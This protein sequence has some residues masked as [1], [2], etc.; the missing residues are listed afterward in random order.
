M[1]VL[2]ITLDCRR[3][4]LLE[5]TQVRPASAAAY[6]EYSALCVPYH[7][8]AHC[9]VALHLG[10]GVRY[11]TIRR[12]EAAEA[13][14]D[15]DAAGH[16][17]L[18]PYAGAAGVLAMVAFA[19]IVNDATHGFPGA[20]I[21]GSPSAAIAAAA[22]QAYRDHEQFRRLLP[23]ARSQRE[24]SLRAHSILRRNR[25]R[26]IA[27]GRLLQVQGRLTGD[28]VAAAVRLGRQ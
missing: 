2:D 7:E 20:I 23:D 21:E 5:H 18:A 17:A 24:A 27:V 14:G 10:L 16:T 26:V 9:V 1:R 13:S 12:E 19:G 25:E 28:E 3:E 4:G 11:V 6:M 22:L 15:P 8:A